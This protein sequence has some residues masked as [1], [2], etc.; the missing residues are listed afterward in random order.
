[1]GTVVNYNGVTM[2]NV[3]TRQWD[4]EMV[5]D[6]SHT[7]ALY[8][9]FRLRFEGLLHA[10][11]TGP[12][13]TGATAVQ[14]PPATAPARLIDIQKRILMP[15]CVLAVTVADSGGQATPLFVCNPP[16]VAGDFDRDV[17]NGPKPTDF[18]VLQV[19]G[20]RLFRVAFSIE[21]CKLV[22]ATPPSAMP[23]YLNNRWSVAEDMD[24]N[25]FTTRTISGRLVMSMA[26]PYM[27]AY[28]KNIVV[29]GLEEGFRRERI[30][31]SV[32]KTGLQCDY[33]VTDR[34]IHT[35]APWPATKMNAVHTQAT[36][37]GLT[38]VSEVQVS[39]EGP[40][41]ADKRL[42]ITR[43]MQIIDAK[44]NFINRTVNKEWWPELISI[45]DRIGETNAVDAVARIREAITEDQESLYANL[46]KSM[47]EQLALP[48]MDSQPHAYDPKL[49]DA[50]ALFGY[51]PHTGERQPSVLMTLACFLQQPCVDDHAIKYRDGGT[52]TAEEGE[53]RNKYTPEVKEN[54]GLTG[55]IPSSD[56]DA[57]STAHRANVYTYSRITSRYITNQCRVQLPI[58]ASIGAGT[59]TTTTR[60]FRL[61]LPQCRRIIELDIERVGEWPQIIPPDD[62]YAD[63]NL[64]G[65]LLRHWLEPHPPTL[66]ADGKTKIYR[67]TAFYLYALNRPPTTSESFRVGVAPQTK[68]TKDDA[69]GRFYPSAYTPDLGP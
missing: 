11:T 57:W 59:P 23:F 35:A 41:H 69:E 1:V 6:D 63:D 15:R 34:Q 7:D 8:S 26:Q 66:A 21:C 48:D 3:V 40:P 45:T 22:C 56:G 62:S 60:C 42:L 51:V 18:R 9:K 53:G 33:R 55:T 10:T 37:D 49:S 67:V 61:A 65:L 47:G 38:F 4:Q 54:S 29:P 43:A 68:Y 39:L 58:A 17:A 44:L 28:A 13:W 32:D 2:H 31:F 20:A 52:E 36:Q 50:P 24:E 12:V 27:Q 16:A 46:R 19:V 14:P 64:Y 30:E 25:A 5:Y